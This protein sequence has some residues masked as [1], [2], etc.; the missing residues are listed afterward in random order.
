MGK[1]NQ[2]AQLGAD[3]ARTLVVLTANKNQ[4]PVFKATELKPA[5][6]RRGGCL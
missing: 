6:H 2:P 3:L 1:A 4:L 5:L